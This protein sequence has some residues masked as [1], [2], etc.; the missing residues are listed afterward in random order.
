MIFVTFFA[1]K[2][3][4][5]LMTVWLIVTL[6]F[7]ILRSSGNP[8]AILLGPE[9]TVEMIDAFSVS[10]GLDRPLWQQYWAY[11]SLVVQGDLGDSFVHGRDALSVVLEHIPATLQ[12]TGTSLALAI[13]IG[14]PLGMVAALNRGAAIDR[15]AMATAVAGYCIPNFFLAV[16]LMLVL[17]IHWT[18]LPTSGGSSLSHMVMPVITLGTAGAAILARFSRSAMLDTLGSSYLKAAESRRLPT[19][20]LLLHHAIPNA[21]IPV[22]TV[23]GFMIG[24]LISGSIVTET[25]FAWPGMGRLL[26]S[27]VANRDI[28]IVQVI[29]LLAGVTMVM[30][31]LVIDLLHGLLDPRIRLT[32]RKP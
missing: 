23:I 7:V 15:I 25:V 19:W 10:L 28:P 3:L 16:V 26:V 24:A 11:L 14:I 27:S 9:A 30:T 5:A 2:A 20:R 31:N 12:L 6:V 1:Q 18:L 29:V 17:S 13:A 32:A 4:R 8:A 21:A 22:V